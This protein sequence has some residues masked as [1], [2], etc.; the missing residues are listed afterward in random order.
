MNP[1]KLE[2]FIRQNRDRFD[3]LEPSP[4]VWE[5]IGRARTRTLRVNWKD[6][7]WK[8]AAVVVIFTG[9]YFFHDFVSERQERKQAGNLLPTGDPLVK[10]LIEAEVFYTALI[11]EKKEELFRLASDSPMIHD[12][13]ETEFSE[14][15][16]I[17][18]ELKDDL[19]DN[20]DNTEVIE[21]M[22]MNYRIKLEI[23]EELLHQINEAKN[24][25]NT[26]SD[27]KEK[28]HI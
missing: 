25:I 16:K 11:S 18:K 20:A 10:E 3:D 12:E 2:Q 14:L 9:S 6:M 13:V 1:D 26:E 15:D 8:A 21:A 4:E 17:Y 27:E 5:R 22:I 7:A 23:L 24:I 19:Q 28:I